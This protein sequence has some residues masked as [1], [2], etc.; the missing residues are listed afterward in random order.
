ML[1]KPISLLT[2]DNNFNLS[3]RIEQA[4][5]EINEHPISY[6]LKKP[7]IHQYQYLLET[8]YPETITSTTIN[9][10]V[11]SKA[12]ATLINHNTNISKHHSKSIKHLKP[13]KLN[14]KHNPTNLHK[15]DFNTIELPLSFYIKKNNFC[16]LNSISKDNVKST[17]DLTN[18]SNITSYSQKRKNNGIN[19]DISSSLNNINSNN[20]VS[21]YS[22]VALFKGKLFNIN[23]LNHQKHLDLPN[24]INV[25]TQEHNE[26]NYIYKINKARTANE[27]KGFKTCC[28][29]SVPK[30]DIGPLLR[31]YPQEIRNMIEEKCKTGINKGRKLSNEIS[32]RSLSKRKVKKKIKT[33]QNTECNKRNKNHLLNGNNK[34]HMIKAKILHT[35]PI[36]EM[37]EKNINGISWDEFIAI[38]YYEDVD[39]LMNLHLKNNLGTQIKTAIQLAKELKKNNFERIHL[40][41]Y[42]LNICRLANNLNV[43]LFGVKDNKNFI[44]LEYQK[45]PIHSLSELQVNGN[46][47]LENVEIKD[48]RDINRILQEVKRQVLLG[49]L[50]NTKECI[51]KY[52]KRHY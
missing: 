31:E 6:K 13:L 50:N 39:N 26:S 4:Q 46:D 28:T 10:S 48:K 25:S 41:E 43:L 47:I 2:M 15:I 14:I 45:L 5:K 42:G 32:G 34:R 49:K 18:R 1:P 33:K 27:S 35:L 29:F 3:K 37:K 19:K 38:S 30:K 16:S 17:E 40:F 9:N 20:N 21:S 22:T 51:I 7:S 36:K 52:I 44:E 24:V 11:N 23:L 12:L 8:T